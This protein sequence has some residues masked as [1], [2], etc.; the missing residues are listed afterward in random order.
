M[1][2]TTNKTKKGPCLPDLQTLI[3]AG[4]NPVTGLP[5]KAYKSLGRQENIRNDVRKIFRIV[6]EQRAVNRYKWYNLPAGLS[7]QE[8]E[9]LIYYKGSLCFFYFKE[10]K[11]FYFMPYALDGTIDFYGRF[12][13]IHPVPMTSGKEDDKKTNQDPQAALLSTKK[14]NVIKDVVV[15][16][17]EITQDLL[18][19]SAVILRD[20]TNQE[21][22][23]QIC[24]QLLNDPLLGVEADCIAYMQTSLLISTGVQGMRVND[25]D[26]YSEVVDAANKMYDSAISGNPYLPIIGQ[27]DFQELQPKSAL[28]AQ[29]FML[30]LQSVDNLLLKTYGITSGGVYEKK[31]HVLESEEQVNMGND[32]LN[33]QD[34]LSQRQNFCAIVNSIWGTQIWCELSEIIAGDTNGDGVMYDENENGSQSGASGNSNP[35]EGGDE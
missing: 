35:E 10:L 29:E 19:N 23:N 21:S 11:K 33:L 32:M 30:A 12:N 27:V 17:D 22:Q 34:G 15:Y 3:A 20:Y 9:R 7:S 28:K 26:S 4:I 18:D 31:A 25:A 16:A 1:G 13:T 24:R 5:M 6:D 8:L 2:N 14:L